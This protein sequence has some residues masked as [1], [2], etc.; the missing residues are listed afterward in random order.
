MRHEGVCHCEAIRI[1][2]ESEK[3]F[4]P[5]ACQCSFCRRHGARTVSDP[6]GEAELSWSVEPILYRFAS[7]AA[8]Y[9]ICRGCGIYVGAMAEID[10]RVVVTLNLNA[11]D[12]T[13]P[14]LTAEPVSYE[15]ESVE[16]KA[17]RRATGWTPLP[18]SRV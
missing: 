9:L 17:S 2:F 14:E 8:D 11:F 10:G 16:H 7:R 1:A 13:R 18:R 4:A 12:E 5:R 15:G 3:P 6:E